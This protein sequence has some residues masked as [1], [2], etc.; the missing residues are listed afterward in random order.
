M[1][2][3]SLRYWKVKKLQQTLGYASKESLIMTLKLSFMVSSIRIIQN[4]T[5]P[6]GYKTE[7]N[8]TDS[9]SAEYIVVIFKSSSNFSWKKNQIMKMYLINLLKYLS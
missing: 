2:D 5:F 8:S 1:G 9:P 7:R 4:S 3:I 6:V